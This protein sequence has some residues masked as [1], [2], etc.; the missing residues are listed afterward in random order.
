[1]YEKRLEL[2]PEYRRS[3]EV[4]YPPVCANCMP[5]VVEEIREKDEIARVRALGSELRNT[6]GT[7]NRRRTSLTRKERDKLERELR[8]WRI[9][10]CLWA[11][12]AVC[13]IAGYASSQ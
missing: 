10:G 12:S 9:R 8:L 6:K 1:M 5:T 4:R 11:A 7:D 3:I 13:A 2:L